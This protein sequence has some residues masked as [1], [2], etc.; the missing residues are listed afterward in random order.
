MH[1]R[2]LVDILRAAGV[3]ERRLTILSGDGPD[4]T[5]DVAL[6][7]VQPEED[8]WLV[9]G[10]RLEQPF[11]T[12]ITYESTRVAG[13][14]L[15][16]ATRA[17]LDRW[18]ASVGT[19]LKPGDTL[20]LYVTDHGTKNAQDT[21]NNRITLWG[22]GEGLSVGELRA[23]LAGLDRR[24]RV[25]MLMSQCYS[26]SFANAAW[27][28][29][30][31]LPSGNACGYFSTTAERPAYGCY[32]EVRDLDNLGH[33]FDFLQELGQ[34]GSLR[35]G[36]LKVLEE[37]ATPDAPLRTS[38]FF[39]EDLLRRRADAEGKAFETLVDG[40]L[41][42]A[43]RRKG[44]WEPEI[45][46]L[47]AVGRSFGVFSP[48]WLAEIQDQAARLPQVGDQ[49]DTHAKAWKTTLGDAN[50]ANLERFLAKQPAWAEQVS[51]RALREGGSSARELA[52]T[53]LYDLG[54]Y[55]RGDTWM[56]GR[57]SALRGRAETARAL[58]YRMEVRL[59]VVLRM[60]A[61]LVTIAGREYLSRGGT[62]DER[63]AYESLLECESLSLPLSE[64]VPGMQSPDR[65]AFPPLEADLIAAREVLPAWLGIRFGEVPAPL[66]KAQG[67]TP[68]V[69]MV[70][71][72]Y[73][74]S[75]A[76]EADLQVA[77]VILGPP[78]ARFEDPRQIREWTMLATVDQ[79]APL[80]VLRGG[81]RMEVTIVPKPY[82]MKWPDLPGPP[83]VSNAAPAWRPLQLTAYRG[84]LPAD[85]RGSGPHLLYFWATWC[86]PCKAALPEL[87]AFQ[88]QRNTPV[89]AITDE[90]AGTLDTFFGTFDQRFPDLVATDELRRSFLAYG[91]SGTPTFVVVDGD[92][93]IRSYSVGYT[94][95]KGLGIEGWA[96]SERPTA[97]GPGSR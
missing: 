14:A 31:S 92:G 58:A 53:F 28:E 18:F 16:A 2:M 50:R 43:W 11:R 4:P 70:T 90:P 55:T 42:Q 87:L 89:V 80:A 64:P 19:R 32:P 27:R 7:E 49:L 54:E 8:F 1:V 76:E 60:R 40:L 38:D 21:R 46:L 84:E 85:L 82:P 63:A 68:G 5:A 51:D 6:R 88:R 77:D 33:S 10:T 62:A 66:R 48:R 73:P 45:R 72:V 57:L 25:V 44:A 74:D 26:G 37:D 95:A 34:S 93:V 75:P 83:R 65:P 61:I 96:W 78:E 24:V 29:G 52:G 79:P 23:L 91:V 12:P 67:L 81:E 20:L 41:K 17:E 15:K 13:A 22:K 47:D 39:L 56:E 9:T 97:R 59:G 94:P 86:G 30:A 3:S 35:G 69:S 71:A 36:H